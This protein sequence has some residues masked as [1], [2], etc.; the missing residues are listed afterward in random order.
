[1]FVVVKHVLSHI[2][3]MFV[4]YISHTDSPNQQNGTTTET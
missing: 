2:K 1:V 3:F 4:L